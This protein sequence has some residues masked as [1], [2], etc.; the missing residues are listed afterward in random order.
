MGSKDSVWMYIKQYFESESELEDD[1]SS[2]VIKNLTQQFENLLIR[3]ILLMMLKH[4][5]SDSFSIIM[6]K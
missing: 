3:R 1:L 2:E 5:E 4:K 6:H